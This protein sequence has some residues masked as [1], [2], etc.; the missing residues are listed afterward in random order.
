VDVGVSI[1]GSFLGG[2]TGPRWQVASAPDVPNAP[3]RCSG[4][5][6]CVCVSCCIYN[7]NICTSPL[8]IH[9]YQPVT[10]GNIKLGDIRPQT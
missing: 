3:D 6:E 10:L 2:A 1:K 7:Y 8:Y 5:A 4:P 9:L